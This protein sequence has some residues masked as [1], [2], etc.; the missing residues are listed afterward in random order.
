MSIHQ[1]CTTSTLQL[2]A[3]C[4]G[5]AA[6]RAGHTHHLSRCCQ[7]SHRSGFSRRFEPSAR[8][9]IL[10]AIICAQRHAS[11]SLQGAVESRASLLRSAHTTAAF[12]TRTLRN[13]LRGTSSL[14]PSRRVRDVIL[15]YLLMLCSQ[16]FCR[17]MHDGCC[18][19]QVVCRSSL[20]CKCN[21]K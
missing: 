7:T 15:F 9:V 14:A 3:R 5:P 20:D 11:S 8:E 19:M 12:Q 16:L 4:S 17:L 2:S 10:I 13:T 21:C 6:L 1:P 18:H